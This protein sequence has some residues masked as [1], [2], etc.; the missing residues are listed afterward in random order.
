MGDKF[1]RLHAGVTYVFYGLD[2]GR[3]GNS[4]SHYIVRTD[5]EVANSEGTY[6][7]TEKNR[8][9][10]FKLSQMNGYFGAN[11]CFLS[12]FSLSSRQKKTLKRRVRVR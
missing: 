7:L 2:M 11:P 1:E 6:C 9:C 8:K 12:I 10:W 3:N 4:I 5:F